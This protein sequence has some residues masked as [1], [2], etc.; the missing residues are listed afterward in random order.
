MNLEGSLIQSTAGRN[1]QGQ[2]KRSAEFWGCSD[3]GSSKDLSQKGYCVLDVRATGLLLKAL[4]WQRLCFRIN[5]K[6]LMMGAT[7]VNET[8][9]ARKHLQE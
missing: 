8:L 2:P 5:L 6:D 1:A 4:R 9:Q 3:K 7:S